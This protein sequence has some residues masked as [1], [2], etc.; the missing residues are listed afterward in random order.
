[1]S[2]S[3]RACATCQVTKP[4]DDFR[5]RKSHATGQHYRGKVCRECHQRK[6]LA[7]RKAN[8]DR[9]RLY[10]AA[11]KAKNPEYHRR[12]VLENYY[13]RKFGITIAGRDAMLAAQGGVCAICG[14]DAPRGK[15]WCVDHCHTTNRIRAILCQPCNLVLGHATESVDILRSAIKYLEQHK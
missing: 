11:A 13:R 1:M 12:N 9:V 5:L 15:G 4:E 3:L 8:P 10:N 6:G 7:W 2:S 14:T